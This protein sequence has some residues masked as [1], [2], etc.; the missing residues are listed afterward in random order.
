M[1]VAMSTPHE[2]LTDVLHEGEEGADLHVAGIHL[3]AAEPDDADDGEMST[4][5]AQRKHEHEQR[6]DLA[7]DDHDVGVRDAEPGLFDAFTHERADDAH[8]GELLAHD[9]R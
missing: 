7:S 9:A 1:N 4:S 8:T 2:D 3:D 6:A 5:I